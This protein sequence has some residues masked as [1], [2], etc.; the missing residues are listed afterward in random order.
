MLLQQLRAERESYGY[1]VVQ[2][3]QEIGLADILEGTVY[4]ALARIERENLSPAPEADR[5]RLIRRAASEL[6]GLPP[7]PAE[8]NDFLGDK[9]PDSYEQETARMLTYP[10]NRAR[11]ALTELDAAR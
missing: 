4:P 8:V 2:R 3:L 9:S 7:T 11:R 5:E 6:T 10:A 1:E